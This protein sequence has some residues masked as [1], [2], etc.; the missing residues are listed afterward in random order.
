MDTIRSS[1]AW[2]SAGSV[3]TRSHIFPN[4]VLADAGSSENDVQRGA[5]DWSCGENIDWLPETST[6]CS[7]TTLYPTPEPN[8]T[9][10]TAERTISKLRLWISAKYSGL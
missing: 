2:N 10:F 4:G 1:N 8:A 6:K 3:T 5:S 9:R 7:K